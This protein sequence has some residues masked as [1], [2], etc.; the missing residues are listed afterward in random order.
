MNLTCITLTPVLFL[1]SFVCNSCA[2]DTVVLGTYSTVS[3][4]E[5][6][7]YLELKDSGKAVLLLEEW[8]AGKYDSRIVDTVVA[9]WKQ[10][11][12]H[13]ILLYGDIVD[14]LTYDP[15]LSLDELG[16]KGG[17]PGLQ[18]KTQYSDGSLIR[19]YS[20]WKM[21]HEF[22]ESLPDSL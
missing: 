8:D 13:V 20:L 3:E 1:V 22:S 15:Q 5:W 11:D 6:E 17:W 10:Y 12:S 2:N 14:T 9:S 21:P 16:M 4:S 7:L 18:Q 19:S